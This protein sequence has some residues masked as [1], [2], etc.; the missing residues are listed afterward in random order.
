MPVVPARTV[1]GGTMPAVAVGSGAIGTR[2]PC[3]FP[4]IPGKGPVPDP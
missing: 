3:G 4:E 1:A 2:V